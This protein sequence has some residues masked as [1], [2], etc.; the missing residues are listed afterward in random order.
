MTDSRSPS[1][2]SRR[3]ALLGLGALGAGAAL[4]GCDDDR[5]GPAADGL[6]TP[7][8]HV[9]LT[10]M[11][12]DAFAETWQDELVPEFNKDFPTV[13]VTIDSTPY[14]SLVA[15]GVLNGTSKDPDYDLITLDDP[16]TPQLADAGLLLDL[17]RDAASWTDPDYDWDD[18]NSAALGASAWN[19]GQYG[20]PLRSNLLLMIYNRELYAEAGVAEPTPDL[21]WGSFARQAPRLVQATGGD[22]RINSWATGLTWARGELSPPFWQTVLNADGGRLFDDAMRPQFN[23]PDGQAALQ[24]QVDLLRYA[25]PGAKTYNYNEPLDAFRQGRIASLFT[26]G[27]AYQSVAVDS[28]VTTLSPDQV[29]IQTMPAGSRGPSTHRGIWSGAI[30]KNSRH[31]RAAWTLLQWM[32]SKTGELWCANH[33]G[34]FPARRST[35]ASRPDKPWLAAMYDTI[36]SGFSAAEKN[37]M[38]RPRSPQAGAIQQVLADETSAAVQGQHSVRDALTRAAEQISEL[39]EH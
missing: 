22:D 30:F 18:F 26:W 13:D 33:L 17:K 37:Q 24:L 27:S 38:W 6:G 28:S 19:G 4:T 31:P 3:T 7:D 15:K 2:L 21:S 5:S 14:D 1:R 36:Q 23:T 12:N 11:S 8:Q 16:W 34:S 39:L 29:G 20:V 32:S 9:Q 10:M 35:L 25:P